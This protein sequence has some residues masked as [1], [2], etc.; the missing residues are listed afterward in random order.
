M[1][2][3]EVCCQFRVNSRKGHTCN[4]VSMRSLPFNMKAT[5]I[6][7]WDWHEAGPRG[8]P[9]L[10][11]VYSVKAKTTRPKGTLLMMASQI[12]T[13]HQPPYIHHWSSS[14]HCHVRVCLHKGNPH[15]ILCFINF[16]NRC[17]HFTSRLNYCNG[18][19]GLNW[20]YMLSFLR[21]LWIGAIWI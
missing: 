17:T 6:T 19:Y 8:W 3:Q 21:Q 9:P 13:S 5:L 18:P 4:H 1:A 10:T 2:N 16:S 7:N 15:L 12:T 14:R 20:F 11:R